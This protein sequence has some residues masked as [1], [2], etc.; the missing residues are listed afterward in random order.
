MIDTEQQR[1]WWFATHPEYHSNRPSRRAR[2]QGID[3]YVRERLKYERD[4]T[5]IELL[6]IMKQIF[7]AGGEWEREG[8]PQE[9]PSKIILAGNKFNPYDGGVFDASR[10]AGGGGASVGA[11][12]AAGAALGLPFRNLFRNMR[13]QQIPKPPQHAT[14][15][16]VP[17]ND[18][19]FETAKEARK[20]LEKF[21]IKQYDPVNGVNLPNKP[22]AGEGAYHP[23]LHTEKY[24]Q[25][26]ERLLRGATSKEH[27]REI[28]KGIGQKLLK[29]QFPK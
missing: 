13:A 25:E 6:K 11:P 5:A 4:A 24:Y 8:Q 23:A 29:N 1:R 12:G 17:E 2:A 15:H 28:L 16:I 3:A 20:L 22:E 21:G 27:A 10:M 14:H 9:T 19:R 7:G 26:V 18:S